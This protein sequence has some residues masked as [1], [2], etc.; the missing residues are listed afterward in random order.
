MRENRAVGMSLL[1]S[2]P[3]RNNLK[4]LEILSQDQLIAIHEASLHLL[5]TIG[6]EFMGAAARQKFR[7]AGASVDDATGLVKIPREVVQEALKTAPAAFVLTSRNP[8]RRVHAGE[9]FISF[10]LVAGP[11]NVHDCVDGRRNGNYKDYISLIKLAHSFDIIH[12][13]GNQPTAPIEMPANTRHL[14]C[15]LANV[16]YS[17]RV[18]HCS[19]IGRNRALD[20]I[21]VM[22]ISRGKTRE[23][24][25]DDP[26][27]LT[28][29]S[30]NSPR[31]FDESMSD[32]LMAMSEFGQPVV[33]TP[34]TLMGAM[35]PVSL[36]AALTQQNAEALSGIVLT[37][38]T[39]PGTPVVY[40]AFTSNVDMRSGAPA[41]GTPENARAT[42]A[43]GQLARLYHLPYRASNSSASNAV[44][45]QA[46]Y[47][48]QMSIWS[49]VMGHANFVYHGA[50]WM[51]GGLTASFEKVILDV[52][53]LQMMAMTIAPVDV[54]AKEI[55]EGLD[56]ISKVPTG[57]HFFGAEHTLARYETAFYQP[58]VSN[59]QNYE[60]WDLA[61]HLDATQRAT[62]IWQNVLESY[63]QPPM[64]PAVREA[65]DAFVA[66]RKEELRTVDH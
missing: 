45:A 51:E 18:Y 3:L 33:V 28:I 32:G 14:D 50:G 47:E 19:A 29:I 17:D 15:Y 16:I 25:I 12:F 40:G 13:V 52:E 6:I 26:S 7:K 36:A 37:Q 10:G 55:A 21:D 27:V 38:L 34:F 23:E 46:A 39:R 43:A 65:L 8:A 22:A 5:E 41:F 56:A 57:G 59:W 54:N 11:P 31:R 20:G 9:N 1:G 64:D 60:N 48:S 24:I 63:Q 62:A 2:P 42:L 4:P 61:G 30:V 53:M 49:A 44:D 66:R 35:T 58:L